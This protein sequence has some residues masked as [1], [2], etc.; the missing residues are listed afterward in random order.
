LQSRAPL[1]ERRRVKDML[2]AWT[3]ARRA[4]G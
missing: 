2:L 1:L 4:H 3:T